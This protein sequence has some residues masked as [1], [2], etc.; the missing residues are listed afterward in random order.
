MKNVVAVDR[1]TLFDIAIQETGTV[2]SVFAISRAN[3][4]SVSDSLS[5]DVVAVTEITDKNVT[6][7]FKSQKPAT[8]VD[9]S[10]ELVGNEIILSDGSIL[11][12]IDLTPIIV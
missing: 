4:K 7:M 5:R 8:A 11:N 10:E 3:N 12:S 6:N 9:M 2:E 1:Q